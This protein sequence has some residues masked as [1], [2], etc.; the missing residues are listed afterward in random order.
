MNNDP[1]SYF[2]LHGHTIHSAFSEFVN[3]SPE[4]AIRRAKEVG[5]DGIAITGHDT[6]KGLDQAMNHAVNLG[7]ILV[8]GVEIS[9]RVGLRTPHILAL[10]ITP[11]IIGGKRLPS[12][13]HPRTVI[14]WIHDHGGLAIA[15]HP[16]I[17]GGQTSLSF[18]QVLSLGNNLNGIEVVTSRGVNAALLAI[19]EKLNI[20]KLGS[21]DYHLLIQ[22]GSVATRV[23]GKPRTYEDVVQAIRDRQ[24][25]GFVRT[26]LP[27][28]LRKRTWR[29]LLKQL[30]GER[31]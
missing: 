23:F 20:A 3:Y 29:I 19:A 21:S 8:P 17:G 15:A 27:P 16:K 5:L 10:G 12:L 13:K 4:D 2:D 26:P 28:E 14:S 25:E 31:L 1:C 6:L 30:W 11:E 18:E 7:I 9:S 22:I 24:V